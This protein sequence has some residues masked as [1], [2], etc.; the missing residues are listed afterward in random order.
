MLPPVPV[1]ASS[2]DMPPP[3]ARRDVGEMLLARLARVT[4]TGAF[5]PHIDGLR[6]AAIL[7][8]FLYHL[9]G[10]YCAKTAVSVADPARHLLYI[11]LCQGYLGV[12]LFFAISGFILAL[13]FAARFLQ[14]RPSPSLS[15]YF[16][17]RLT[18]LEPPYFINMLL[19][20][21][22][23][24]LVNH[25]PLPY[26]LRHFFT[27]LVY[28]HNIVF[29]Q[30]NVVNVVAWSLEIEVQF[31]LLA[32]LFC[33]LFL[34]PS[35]VLRR[36]LII[37]L[38]LVSMGITSLLDHLGVYA[39][40]LTLLNYLPFFL[41]GFILVDL[42]LNEW[43]QQQAL[44]YRWD[45]AGLLAGIMLIAATATM[46]G[47]VQA[48]GGHQAWLLGVVQP[49]CILLAYLGAFRGRVLSRLVQQRWL[50]A[51]G[52]MCYTIYLYHFLLISALGRL[53]LHARISHEYA[54]N[55]LLQ[56]CL[57][58]GATLLLSSTLFLLFEKPFMYRDWPRQWR[59]RLRA[60][61]KS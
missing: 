12:N 10:F 2:V 52:G 60:T 56:F 57:I 17:R 3:R 18:R 15:G 43:K 30:Y 32:P 23:V 40:R 53:T 7:S 29:A 58:G 28:L 6:F 19:C 34:L 8:V 1:D 37:T 22:L 25:P 54:I 44:H 35:A 27:G 39:V 4:S 9:N 5:I 16:L 21:L 13:P 11:V 41:V 59:E 26:T 50:A 61:Q 42:Y 48:F 55:L 49:A 33:R 51:I 47:G 46:G 38:A 24:L 31:Y 14:R 20:L 45:I 36:S